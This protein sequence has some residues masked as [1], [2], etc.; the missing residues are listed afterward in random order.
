MIL[1]KKL[2][3][4]KSVHLLWLWCSWDQVHHLIGKKWLLIK[5]ISYFS[6]VPMSNRGILFYKIQ[7]SI[8]RLLPI[9]IY[10][11]RNY[12]NILLEYI[13]IKYSISNNRILSYL[14]WV[15]VSMDM[16]TVCS[17]NDSQSLPYRGTSHRNHPRLGRE[18]N[19]LPFFSRAVYIFSGV[20]LQLPQVCFNVAD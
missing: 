11:D 15:Y 4:T 13:T 18:L 6:N 7:D 16:V 14:I 8:Y 10:G 1:T 12:L 9:I 19:W 20:A 3:H 5:N 2:K 17:L